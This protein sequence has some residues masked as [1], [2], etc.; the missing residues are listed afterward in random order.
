ML[1]VRNWVPNPEIAVMTN[2]KITKM[3]AYHSWINATTAIIKKNDRPTFNSGNIERLND[4]N[5]NDHDDSK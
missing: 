2:R 4:D 3:A 5:D 1:L